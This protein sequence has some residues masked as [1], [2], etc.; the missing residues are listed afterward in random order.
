MTTSSPSL[1]ALQ[2]RKV[3]VQRKLRAVEAEMVEDYQQLV[4]PPVPTGNRIENVMQTA[5]R[6]WWLVDGA[7]TGYKLMRRLGGFARLFSSKKGKR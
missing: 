6:A 2:L 3:Q 1:I 5:S 7:L 4:S